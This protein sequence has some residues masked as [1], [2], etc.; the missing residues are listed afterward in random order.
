M[1]SFLMLL[2]YFCEVP[3]TYNSLK[4]NLK[5][6]GLHSYDLLSCKSCNR[7]V[8]P[9]HVSATESCPICNS[10][11]KIKVDYV[12]TTSYHSLMFAGN[13]RFCDEFANFQQEITE[14]IADQ[15]NANQSSSKTLKDWY[16]GNVGKD[17]LQVFNPTSTIFCEIT[18]DGLNKSKSSTLDAWPIVLKT[19][20]LPPTIRNDPQYMFVSS[21]I[22]YTKKVADIDNSLIP[23]LQEME[24]LSTHSVKMYNMVTAKLQSFSYCV[25]SV[26]CDLDAWFKAFCRKH[27]ASKCGCFMG[28]CIAKSVDNGVDKNGRPQKK[29][30]WN[31]WSSEVRTGKDIL[32]AG[33]K[34]L[35]IGKVVNGMK[36]VPVFAILTY[37][38]IVKF[39]TID[40]MHLYFVHGIFSVLLDATFEVIPK[41]KSSILQQSRKLEVQMTHE[42]KRN[43]RSLDYA[44]RM[45]AEEIMNYTQFFIIIILCNTKNVPSN[46]ME[47]WHTF[48][49]LV[50]LTLGYKH[51]STEQRRIKQLTTNLNTQIVHC[52]TSKKVRFKVHQSRHIPQSI[53]NHGPLRYKWCFPLENLLS[54][55]RA[56]IFGRSEVDKALCFSV[57]MYSSLE[58][59]EGFNF[60][61]YKDPTDIIY[62][63]N[64][65]KG[66]KC[67][68]TR[69]RNADC[70]V[71]GFPSDNHSFTLDRLLQFFPDIKN[72]EEIKVYKRVKING[73]VF[74]SSLYDRAIR[75][76]SK[77][78]EVYLPN[79]RQIRSAKDPRSFIARIEAFF[80]YRC[81]GFAYVCLLEDI[82]THSVGN[83]RMVSQKLN[84]SFHVIAL[85]QIRRKGHLVSVNAVEQSYCVQENPTNGRK[86][87]KYHVL[88]T[89]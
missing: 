89:A 73:A 8:W 20:S 56:M 33:V 42:Y 11:A 31:V 69:N 57:R 66:K 71:L 27:W 22:T 80:Y 16:N 50:E 23:V 3:K 67:Y 37:F 41:L 64:N 40:L 25:I 58:A 68:D 24:Y 86:T 76:Q 88:C 29:I 6:F 18:F 39:S 36:R 47:V 81:Y 78:V 48:I 21:M 74:H 54:F 12:P 45:K 51:T 30:D 82:G 1:D 46:I 77:F 49:A 43:Y 59:I 84:D 83:F 13:K 17:M 55:I 70:M 7:Y 65:E 63:I 61:K 4:A 62:T 10:T 19:A 5:N 26:S 79:E 35:Q 9:N 60:T 52:F 15:K 34:A 28:K 2:Q 32:A 72:L 75:R 14:F 85:T 44:D 53:E 87:K 38:D